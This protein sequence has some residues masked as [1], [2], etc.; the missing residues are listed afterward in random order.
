MLVPSFKPTPYVTKDR[1]RVFESSGNE[2][3]KTVKSPGLNLDLPRRDPD[4]A[5]LSRSMS[6]AIDRGA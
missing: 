6:S 5:A 1:S 4:N 2:I 3:G